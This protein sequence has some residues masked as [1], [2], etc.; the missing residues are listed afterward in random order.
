MSSG[1]LLALGD[2]ATL[3]VSRKTAQRWFGAGGQV[4]RARH[5]VDT[6]ERHE[7]LKAEIAA[8]LPHSLV[9]QEPASRLRLAD[10]I[11]RS[12]ELALQFAA[13]WRW[14][15]PPSSSITPCG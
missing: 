3:V 1:S 6:A 5:F 13:H 8:R 14:L 10:E 7:S 9:V 11:L 12:S 15:W 2:G 4:D